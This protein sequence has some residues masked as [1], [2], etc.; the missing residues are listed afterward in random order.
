MP[1]CRQEGESRIDSS[2]VRLLFLEVLEAT[3]GEP[4]LAASLLIAVSHIGPADDVPIE[5]IEPE[6]RVDTTRQ[7]LLARLPWLLPKRRLHQRNLPT[8]DPEGSAYPSSDVS[9]ARQAVSGLRWKQV[10]EHLIR[11]FDGTFRQLHVQQ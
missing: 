9:N 11:S 10:H 2:H 7:P 6:S 1:K 3:R 4:E 5:L 8:E